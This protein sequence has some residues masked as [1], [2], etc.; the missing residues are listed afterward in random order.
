LTPVALDAMGG[1]HAPEATVAGAVRAAQRLAVRV[2]LVGDQA[3]LEAE[4]SR[5]PDLPDGLEIVHANA[6]IAMDETPGPALL[7]KRDASIVVAANLVREGRASAVVSAGNSG[8][9]MGA[10][11]LRLGLL[12]GIDRPAIATLLPSRKKAVVVLDAGA[13][14][15]PRPENL[16]DF[17]WMGS[18]YAQALLQ[19]ERPR[20]GILSIGEEPA[21][22]NA[23]V[24]HA[25]PLIAALPINFIGNVEG[26]HI[27]LGD[28]DVVVC[29]G[30]VGNVI[31]KA[32]EG[33]AE[34]FGAMLR[35]RLSAGLRGRLGA[36]L[37]RH[38][39]Q[40]L[41]SQFDYASHGGALLVGVNGIC[42]IAH[43]RSTPPAIESAIRVA[44][45]LAEQ[46]VVDQL[47]ASTHEP[48]AP[49]MEAHASREPDS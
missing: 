34:L 38:A 9:A 30:F 33:Y 45:E 27:A 3:Q 28:V 14:L 11:A 25:H 10:A 15:D 17:A 42:V 31:L 48:A 23:L 29:D 44:N 7:H 18:V 37:L 40:R 19:I 22:G 20:V 26:R 2:L 16:R 49:P 24:K 35:E 43:G 4:L 13:T 6:V 47:K 36:W 21:K 5:H 8:A 41:V 1:D 39:L 32:T 46:G 12:P